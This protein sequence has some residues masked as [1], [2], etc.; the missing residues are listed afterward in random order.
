M[1]PYFSFEQ[2]QIGSITIYTWGALV[3]L[4]FILGGLYSLREARL[5]GL[6][7][8]KIFN[9]VLVIFVSSIIGA[10]VAYVLQYG[11]DYFKEPAEIFKIW[12]GGLMFYGGFFG[13]IIGGLTYGWKKSLNLPVTADL[14][15]PGAVIGLVVGRLGCLLVNDHLGRITNIAWAIKF[16][17]GQLRH[18]V[19][20][21]LLISNILLLVLVFYLK[22]RIRTAGTL[23]II[24]IIWYSSAR[25]GLDFFRA[26]DDARIS[27]PRVW[28]VTN[29]QIVSLVVLLLAAVYLGYQKYLKYNKIAS[30]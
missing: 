9:L 27:D 23:S 17:D 21:Y 20:F 30:N 7:E 10:R 16:P 2:F 18:P 14:L 4:G 5:R 29:S 15:V 22:N 12:E 6:E 13:G 24:F 3:G 8:N 19:I 1:F 28:G 26:A 11:M 25:F